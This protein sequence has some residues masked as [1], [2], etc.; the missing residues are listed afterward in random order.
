MLLN[1]SDLEF[2][3]GIYEPAED[4]FLLLDSLQ[5]LPGEK[6][7]DM[8]TGSGILAIESALRGGIVTAV[9]ISEDALL[10]AANNA[11]K[12]GVTISTI[13]SDLFSN[14]EGLF[15]V[16]LFNPPYL[17]EEEWSDPGKNDAVWNGGGD[18]ADT[19]RRF[20]HD[21][22][23]HVRGRCYLLFSSI[24][25]NGEETMVSLLDPNFDFRKINEKR[26]SFET[27][28]VYEIKRKQ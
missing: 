18:G 16:V 1:P 20:L 17:P 22:G 13:R 6:V 10:C 24:T 15:D 23:K 11:E 12:Q 19:I 27:L 9:D 7:L 21:L 3:N 14:I 28:F 8:G 25:G 4:S 2:P 26:I 5:I